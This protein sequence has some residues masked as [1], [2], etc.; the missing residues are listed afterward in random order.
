MR[1]QRNN[2]DDSS[3]GE[4]KGGISGI[5]GCWSGVLDRLLLA[6]GSMILAVEIEMR[7]CSYN[8]VGF[9]L[10]PHVEGEMREITK[11]TML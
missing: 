1:F 11:K 4:I 7:F 3:I 5:C 2:D 10:A 8:G 6:C 9:V